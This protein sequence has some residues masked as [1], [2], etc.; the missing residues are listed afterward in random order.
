L[1]RLALL[2]RLADCNAHAAMSLFIGC[3]SSTPKTFSSHQKARL[4][5]RFCGDKADGF[6]VENE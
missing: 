1:G 3:V 2:R 4:V 5:N 6:R